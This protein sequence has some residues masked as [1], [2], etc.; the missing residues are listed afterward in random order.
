MITSAGDDRCTDLR[1]FRQL[2]DWLLQEKRHEK[3]I[4]CGDI[5]VLRKKGL[6]DWKA[7]EMTGI[8]VNFPDSRSASCAPA[9]VKA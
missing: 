9:N 4:E 2:S 6:K 7:R 8:P 3:K 5:G 1:V